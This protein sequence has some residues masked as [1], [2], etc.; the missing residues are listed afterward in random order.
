MVDYSTPTWKGV[1]N[2]A[3][4]YAEGNY[5][6]DLI[7]KRGQPYACIPLQSPPP[8]PV[9]LTLVSDASSDC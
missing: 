4:R 7:G 1:K 8:P 3:L 9:M 2:I 6:N 5:E